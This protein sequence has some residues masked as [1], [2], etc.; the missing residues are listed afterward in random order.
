[1]LEQVGSIFE[2]ELSRRK[3]LTIRA[4]GTSM[5]PLIGPNAR[6]V[7][8]ACQPDRLQVG[9]IVC[10]RN[11]DRW[12]LHRIYG[13]HFRTGWLLLKGDWRG[14]LDLPVPPDRVLARVGRVLDSPLP[15]SVWRLVNQ[16][17]IWLVVWPV[18]WLV[19]HHWGRECLY[20][21][22]RLHRPLMFL[23][24]VRRR[25]QTKL[26]S[27]VG[28]MDSGCIQSRCEYLLDYQ[29]SEPAQ[30]A[31]RL[32][33]IKQEQFGWGAGRLETPGPEHPGWDMEKDR[34]W[35]DFLLGQGFVVCGRRPGLILEYVF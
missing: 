21:L 35:I 18:A 28:P 9:D 24:R 27:G 33:Q 29:A 23:E 15:A 1:M 16:L 32:E 8:E 34:A 19:E 31:F 6:V 26:S 2:Q 10:Y 3:A 17:L 22:K 14:R 11:Q 5:W 4:T 20:W 7:L 12:V 25:W 30:W 13:F